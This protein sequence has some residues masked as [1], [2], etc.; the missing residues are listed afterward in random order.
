[1]LSADTLE[2]LGRSASTGDDQASTGIGWVC[3]TEQSGLRMRGRR[4][5]SRRPLPEDVSVRDI[6]IVAV[7]RLA[8]LI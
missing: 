8:S 6:D 1:M 5:E 4:R 7:R 3:G 2:R